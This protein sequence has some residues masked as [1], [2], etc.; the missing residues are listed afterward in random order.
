MFFLKEKEELLERYFCLL[1]CLEKESLLDK[2]TGLYSFPYFMRRL[3]EELIRA[4]RYVYSFSLLL[5]DLDVSQKLKEKFGLEGEIEVIKALGEDIKISLRRCDLLSYE[6]EGRIFVLLPHTPS[7]GAMVVARRLY[8]K[9]EEHLKKVFPKYHGPYVVVLYYN[10]KKINPKR[11]IPETLLIN[12]IKK[13][14]EFIK[15]QG[16]TRISLITLERDLET[17]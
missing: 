13:G 8:P 3:K 9:I 16:K 10:P 6:D 1:E 15:K 11:D 14:I 17:S 4:R 2:K 12:L 7:N 5:I